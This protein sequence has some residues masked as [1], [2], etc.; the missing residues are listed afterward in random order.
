MAVLKEKDPAMLAET[1]E[2][3]LRKEIANAGARGGI[4]VLS[5][6]I[7]SALVAVLLKK[8]SDN[9]MLTVYLPVHSIEQDREDALLMVKTFD[10]PFQ[11]VDLSPLY[12]EFLASLGAEDVTAIAAANIKPRLRMTALY[13]LGQSNNLLV[14]GTGNRPERH[15]GYFTKYGDGGA[16]LLPLGDLLKSEVRSVSRYLGIPEPLIEKAPSAGLWTGQ[17]DE[18]EMGMSYDVIDRYL[19]EGKGDD[20]ITKRIERMHTLTAHKRV[21]PPVCLFRR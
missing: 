5:G 17:T 19:A 3:W 7:D 18:E 20:T 4:V 9:N 15:L 2:N 11:E 13:A 1:I 16:D 8:V 12:D 6:G 14:C 21:L 10:L